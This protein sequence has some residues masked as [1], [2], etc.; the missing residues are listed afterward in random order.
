[1]VEA[2]TAQTVLGNHEFNAVAWIARNEQGEWSRAHTPRNRDQ[3]GVFLAAVG[4]GSPLHHEWIEWF[5]NQPMWLDVG[6]LRIVHAC[7]HTASLDVLG[8]GALT[9]EIVTAAKGTPHYEAL[10]VVLKG[11]EIDMCGYGYADKEGHCRDKGRL[12]WWDPNASTLANGVEIPGG[13]TAC[14]GRPF[15]PLPDIPLDRDALPSA[16]LDVPV[17]YGHYWRSGTDPAIDNPK[18]ACLDWSVAKDGP[19]VAYRWSGEPELTNDHLV[20]AR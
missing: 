18:T 10:E 12:R 1:M 17:L 20:A 19:L 15:G 11:P 14:D 8:D 6:D 13:V 7:W 2:G 16:S 9:H 5:S 4:E 3:H